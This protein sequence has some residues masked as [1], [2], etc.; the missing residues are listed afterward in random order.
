MHI[1]IFVTPRK[2]E[3]TRLITNEYTFNGLNGL[4][5]INDDQI[6]IN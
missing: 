1:P 3:K 2:R 4:S 5:I 6:L